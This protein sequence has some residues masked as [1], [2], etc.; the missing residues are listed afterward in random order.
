MLVFETNTN[1]TMHIFSVYFLVKVFDYESHEKKNQFKEQFFRNTTQNK[2][3]RK[4]FNTN[5]TNS[6]IDSTQTHTKLNK[7]VL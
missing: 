6:P 7:L 3:K 1:S 2:T 5:E 4:W